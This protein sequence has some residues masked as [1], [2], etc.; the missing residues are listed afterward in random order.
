MMLAGKRVKL[1]RYAVH[2]RKLAVFLPSNKCIIRSPVSHITRSV[3]K[4]ELHRGKLKNSRGI[5]ETQI[6]A[7][8]D[9]P[10]PGCIRY[11]T[12]YQRCVMK[13]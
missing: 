13:N 1:G 7:H 10:E 9:I 8:P 2:I 6:V 3:R 4:H 11:I 12:K 5:V